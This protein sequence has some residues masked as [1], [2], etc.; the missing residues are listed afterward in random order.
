MSVIADEQ[1]LA[2]A[3]YDAM[4]DEDAAPTALVRWKMGS[5]GRR[6]ANDLAA[7]RTR[8][9][10][11]WQADHGVDLDGWPL[12]HPPAVLWLSDVAVAACLRCSWLDR[13]GHGVPEAAAAARRHAL[14]YMRDSNVVAQQILDAPLPVWLREVPDAAT[15]DQP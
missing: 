3:Y 1:R 15:V 7:A 13:H 4:Y 11:A 12:P 14:E 6:I 5:T 2:A 8:S 9:L 10:A